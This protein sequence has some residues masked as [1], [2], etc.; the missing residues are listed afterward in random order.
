MSCQRCG[1]PRAARSERLGEVVCARCLG[2]LIP[3]VE[4]ER[5]AGLTA[6]SGAADEDSPG[7]GRRLVPRVLSSVAPTRTR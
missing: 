3:P 5:I 4:H 6:R 2:E 1:Y 7:S